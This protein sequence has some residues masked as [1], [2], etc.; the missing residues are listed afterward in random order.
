MI[1]LDGTANKKNLGA[2]AILGVSLAVAQAAAEYTQ[3]AA[4]SATWA[5]SVP[6]CCPPR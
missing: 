3:P 2:N 4:V 5:A 6:G 1:E